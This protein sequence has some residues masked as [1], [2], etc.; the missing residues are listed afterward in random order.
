MK[1]QH[2]STDQLHS[3][4]TLVT[5]KGMNAIAVAKLFNVKTHVVYNLLRNERLG[6]MTIDKV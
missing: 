1:K 2:L 4:I 5:E 3:I 6:S